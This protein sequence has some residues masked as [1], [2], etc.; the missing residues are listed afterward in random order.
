MGSCRYCGDNNFRRA[1]YRGRDVPPATTVGAT[2]PSGAGVSVGRKP[3]SSRSLSFPTLF[4]DTCRE[5]NAFCRETPRL[6]T[7]TA[8]GY[9]L[10][11]VIPREVTSLLES[12]NA[13]KEDLQRLVW[14]VVIR[15]KRPLRKFLKSGTNPCKKGHAGF[16][17]SIVLC[18]T[19]IKVH[20]IIALGTPKSPVI[21]I[22]IAYGGGRAVCQ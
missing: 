1:T 21:T 20:L 13:R 12:V 9:K 16:P 3:Q 6:A 10:G 22:R 4:C 19:K 5:I 14:D 7:C 15:A 11:V 17:V 2:A 8:Y 18:K